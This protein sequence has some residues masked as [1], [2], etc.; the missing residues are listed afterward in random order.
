MLIRI[1]TRGSALARTQTASMASRIEALGHQTEIVI[2]RTQG[3]KDQVRPFAE[4]GAPGL[5]VREIET[6][7]LEERV[8]LAVHSFK[9][10]PTQSPPE[11]SIVAMP[12]RVDPADLLLVPA[13]ALETE[14]GALPLRE[15]ATVGTASLRRQ[16]LLAALR[17]DLQVQSLRGNVPTRVQRLKEGAYD[18]ILLAAAGLDRLRA[19]GESS[20]DL[21]GVELVRLDPAL[22]VPAPSQGALALQARATDRDVQAAVQPL[23]Q[24]DAAR[25]VL[26]E[27]ELQRLVEGGCQLPFG[28]WC[29]TLPGGK[30]R[31]HAV[32]DRGAG[33]RRAEAEGSDP[34]SLARR[35][36]DELE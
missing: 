10:L 21:S 4:V 1:G 2:I 22:F 8:D 35:V 36:F 29:Q 33:L 13:D 28:A 16:K 9:D 25:A 31:L 6:A 5:F 30:L 26:A 32:I 11:L 12:E 24:A 20:L 3:D 15:G 18:A 14:A 17:P 27:R 23:H 34:L 19:A 7:L